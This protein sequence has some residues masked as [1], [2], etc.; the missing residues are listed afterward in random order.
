MRWAGH[1]IRMGNNRL[2]KKILF[3]GLAEAGTQGQG[4]PKQKA[5]TLYE[6][7]V[8]DM[9]SAGLIS[10]LGRTTRSTG[11]AWWIQ[12]PDKAQWGVCIDAC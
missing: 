8:G 9:V 2:P 11:Q 1:M 12:A 5:A 4:R 10:A 3:G 6:K 7:E